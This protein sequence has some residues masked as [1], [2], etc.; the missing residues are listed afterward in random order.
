MHEVPD[1]FGPRS[2]SA[3]ALFIITQQKSLTAW[4]MPRII[5]HQ[6]VR[7]RYSLAS[8]TAVGVRP[9]SDQHGEVA[10]SLQRSGRAVLPGGSHWQ[11]RSCGQSP[12]GARQRRGRPAPL[13]P[14]SVPRLRSS[15]LLRLPRCAFFHDTVGRGCALAAPGLGQAQ[16]YR[17]CAPHDPGFPA[18]DS[19]PACI[20]PGSRGFEPRWASMSGR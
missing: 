19:S 3:A 10:P 9:R 20:T 6:H 5:A 16:E 13:R 12:P 15:G 4:L 2:L 7:P 18:A 11:R 8:Y 1:R 17:P 14:R